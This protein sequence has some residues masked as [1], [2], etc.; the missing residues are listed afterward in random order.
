M[1]NRILYFLPTGII[2]SILALLFEEQVI[3]LQQIC[4]WPK[5][6]DAILL[7][8]VVPVI[9]STTAEGLLLK[10]KILLCLYLAVWLPLTIALM[11]I[12]FHFIGRRE[13]FYS[14]RTTHIAV[15]IFVI[16]DAGVLLPLY[17]SFVLRK[18]PE[19][20]RY[21]VM[22]SSYRTNS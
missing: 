9:L 5:I 3:R 11:E 18:I 20:F 15:L 16:L 6:Y 1:K 12:Y 8:V 21:S 4:S 22:S 10:G 13:L 17:F 2:F 14:I 7:M 19:K